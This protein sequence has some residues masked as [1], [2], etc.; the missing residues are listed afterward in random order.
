MKNRALSPASVENH[1]KKTSNSL[2]FVG[3]QGRNQD[4]RESPSPVAFCSSSTK[5]FILHG[6]WRWCLFCIVYKAALPGSPASTLPRR[7]LKG[8][9]KPTPQ[10]SSVL[11]GAQLIHTEEPI[12]LHV[13]LI[14][15]GGKHETCHCFAFLEPLCWPSLRPTGP[16]CPIAQ[17]HSKIRI[18]CFPPS[19]LSLCWLLS[20][21]VKG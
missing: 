8:A 14:N 1:T 5:V 18:K 15:I 10:H 19:H 16:T 12:A 9:A 2:S 20:W 3:P 4:P 7:A 11:R 6:G 13:L 17:Q 21:G